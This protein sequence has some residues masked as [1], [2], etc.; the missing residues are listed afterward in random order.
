MGLAR[1]VILP[2]FWDLKHGSSL[3][4]TVLDIYKNLK[5]V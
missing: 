1:S 3:F 4:S 2:E 5:K